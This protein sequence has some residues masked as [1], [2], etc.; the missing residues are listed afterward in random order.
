MRHE[1]LRIFLKVGGHRDNRD[2]A[3]LGQKIAK[4]VAGLEEVD[5]AGQQEHPAVALR[6]ARQ[7]GHVEPIF[8]IGA[9]DNGLVIAAGLRRLPA[10]SSQS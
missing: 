10:S 2:V 9:V 7:N 5:L 1:D 6:A 8:G 4:Q 3:L